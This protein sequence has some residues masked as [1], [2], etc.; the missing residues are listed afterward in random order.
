MN[1]KQIKTD[2]KEILTDQFGFRGDELIEENTL[3][4]DLCLSALDEVEF[5]YE[6]EDKFEISISDDEMEKIMTVKDVIDIV[7][8]KGN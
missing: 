3:N 6:V 4:Y 7:Y 2:I 1:I 5:I 8:K